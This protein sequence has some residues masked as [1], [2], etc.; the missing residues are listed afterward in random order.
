MKWITIAAVIV[1]LAGPDAM[2]QTSTGTDKLTA[3]KAMFRDE[4]KQAGIVGGSFIFIKD[5][6][7]AASEYYGLANIA[8]NQAV[9][10]NTIY[11]WASNTKAFTGIA[12]MQLRDRGL[13]KLDDPVTK[14]LPELR[15]V[16]NPNGSMDE[17][18]IHHLMTHS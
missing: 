6:K 5:N 18:T 13:L 9:D 4:L 16:H 3:F 11:H 2:M 7:V 12:I 10:E 14:Y 17:I 1:L 15:A 8:K